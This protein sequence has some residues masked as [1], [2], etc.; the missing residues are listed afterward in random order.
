MNADPINTKVFEAIQ[1][2][3]K[4]ELGIQSTLSS[5]DFRV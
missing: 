3:W 4:R 1:Q 2:M 5:M